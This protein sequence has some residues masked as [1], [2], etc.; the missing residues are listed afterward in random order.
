ML[1][2]Y[3]KR[4]KNLIVRF[5]TGEESFEQ[6]QHQQAVKR[7]LREYEK[8][9]KKSSDEEALYNISHYMNIH[10]SIYIPLEDLTHYARDLGLS[11][12]T[13]AGRD[14]FKERFV[15][16]GDWDQHKAKIFPYIYNEKNLRT[17]R[18]LKVYDRI[19]KYGYLS[20][21]QLNAKPVYHDFKEVDEIKV[22]IDRHGNFLK[23]VDCGKHR[24]AAARTLNIREIPVF[25]QGIHYEWAIK[26]LNK[27][28]TDPIEAINL[29]IEQLNCKQPAVAK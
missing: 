4:V 26:C 6:Y 12:V 25:I 22:V 11:Y 16:D 19:K 15:E 2:K 21:K 3:Q 5:S 17:E 23:V 7:S 28:A 10:R 8:R 24:L 27:H 20:Q 18:Y 14:L 9:T 29:E 1:D 13:P